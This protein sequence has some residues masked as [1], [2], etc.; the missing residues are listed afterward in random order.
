[1]L[2]RLHPSLT[3]AW[4]DGSTLQLGLTP[5]HA[6]VFGDLSPADVAV[7]NAMD[8]QHTT[9]QLREIAVE[10]DAAPESAD[11]LVDTLLSAGA[12]V[13]DRLL[14]P[15][16]A[17]PADVPVDHFD[18]Q[19]DPDAATLALLSDASS[20]S[21]DLM[22]TRKSRRVD[23]IGAGRVG[24]T[25]ARLLDAA[26]VGDVRVLDHALTRRHDTAPGG[27]QAD[28][29]GR[30]RGP[31]AEDHLT[32]SRKPEPPSFVIVAPAHG[33]GR[34]EAGEALRA[35]TPHLL[36]QV[37]ESTGVVG[38][39]VRAGQTPCVQCVDMHRTDRDRAWPLILDQHERRPPPQPACDI[40]LATTIA[41]L[42]A[43]Q[44][45][46][47][48]DGFDVATTGG[49]I[50]MTLPLGLPRRR[51]WHMHPGCGCSWD[52]LLAVQPVALAAP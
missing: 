25:I 12:A 34:A 44:A 24:A 3:K 38:P 16:P 40:S 50:E 8:G 7:V 32:S 1:M 5:E 18:E 33:T 17:T 13:D 31:A 29:I 35:G 15:P 6:M 27:L 22:A 37:V 47:Y 23:V 19:P 4:R 52:H 10:Y 28:D 21:A 46:A 2:P 9:K 43:G 26:G 48:L 39:L 42:A 41:G 11:G 51:S 36:V 30:P 45:V 49:T 14:R 20:T